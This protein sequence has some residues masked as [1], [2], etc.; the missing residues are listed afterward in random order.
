M[1]VD[2]GV[3]GSASE[4]LVLSVWYMLVCTGITVFFSQTK[5]NYVH[6]VAFF[7]KAH[8]EIIWFHISVDEVFWVNVLYSAY[9]FEKK[10]NSYGNL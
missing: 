10:K 1:S 7:P 5:V 3:S 6:K 2:A 8:K 9:L 4:I